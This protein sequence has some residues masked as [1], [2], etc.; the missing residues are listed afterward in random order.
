M[1]FLAHLLLAGNNRYSIIGNFIADH[2]KGS[3]IDLYNEQIRKGIRF[4]RSVDEF[5]D[6]N[7][8]VKEAVLSLRPQFHKYAGVVVD[9]YYDHFLAKDWVKYSTEPL[10]DFTARIF[11]VLR[12]SYDILPQ[13]SRYMLPYM[14]AD[15]WLL[16]YRNFEG[17]NQALTGI[18]KRTTFESGLENA[19]DHLKAHYE[20]YQVSFIEFFPQLRSFAQNLH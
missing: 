6:S 1:N 18:S 3:A 8:I 14:I 19:V 20:I 5:T 9:M 16:N 12:S 10:E 4:H 17:L 13:R 11:D 7:D 2:V 15:N